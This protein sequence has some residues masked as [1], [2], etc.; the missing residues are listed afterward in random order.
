MIR[1]G[2]VDGSGIEQVK[3]SK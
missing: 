3:E 1:I 2:P